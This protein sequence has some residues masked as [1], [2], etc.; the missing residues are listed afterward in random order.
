[1]LANVAIK[2]EDRIEEHRSGSARREPV[3]LLCEEAV[4]PG[5]KRTKSKALRLRTGRSS[6]FSR[7]TVDVTE[8][9]PGSMGGGCAETVTWVVT[10]AA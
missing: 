10:P 5:I 8:V 4:T 1:M 7:P 9:C 6:I 3:P 2:I